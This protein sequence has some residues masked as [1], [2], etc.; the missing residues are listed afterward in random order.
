LDQAIPKAKRTDRAALNAELKDRVRSV[1]YAHSY[2]EACRRFYALFDERARFTG[3]GPWDTIGWFHAR[4]GLY[5]AHHLAPGL[6]ADTNVVENV[7]KQLGKK[8]RLME[9]FSSL[10]SAEHFCRLLV[11]CYRF[12]RFIDSCRVGGNGRTP[13]QAAGVDLGSCDWLSFLLN[14][15]HRRTHST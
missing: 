5:T 7:I 13:L 2:E 6:P 14:R 1:L 9:G 10:E 4:F 15:K 12:K 11:A 3:T 8:L